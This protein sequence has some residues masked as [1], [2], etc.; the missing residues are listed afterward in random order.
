[1]FKGGYR[2]SNWAT[3][4]G[5]GKGRPNKNNIGLPAGESWGG[6]NREKVLGE[7]MEDEV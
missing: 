7:D 1:M 6:G 4:R 2:T 5:N 3:G